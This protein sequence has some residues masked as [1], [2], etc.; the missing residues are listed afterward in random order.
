VPL[1]VFNEV[2]SKEKKEKLGKQAV[3]IFTSTTITLIKARP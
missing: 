1:L 3:K 2:S